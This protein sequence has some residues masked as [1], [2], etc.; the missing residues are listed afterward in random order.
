RLHQRHHPG[1]QRRRVRL[2]TG[3]CS[4]VGLSTICFRPRPLA[5]ALR[6][7]AGTGA[8]EI[9]L[10]ALPAATHHAPLPFLGRS[11]E[12]VSAI[13]AEGLRTG[14]V[15][16]DPG[17]LNDPTLTAEALT[18]V[19]TPPAQLAAALGAALIVPAGRADHTPIVDRD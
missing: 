3:R 9:D 19:V 6:L 10:G 7:S 5:P 12:Y 17:D 18:A 1:H 15:N 14:A 4:R 11:A 13:R 2:M 8:S 16:A